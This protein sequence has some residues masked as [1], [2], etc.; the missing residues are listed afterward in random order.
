ML[1]KLLEFIVVMMMLLC[2]VIFMMLLLM[3]F[4][5]VSWVYVVLLFVVWSMFVCDF[6]SLLSE[7]V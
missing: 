7:F 4:E 3:R 1:F 5:V 6:F 2:V